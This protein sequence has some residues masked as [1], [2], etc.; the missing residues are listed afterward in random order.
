MKKLVFIVVVILSFSSCGSNISPNDYK[1]SE[2]GKTLVKW[3]NKESISIDM[4]GDKVLRNVDSIG[5][6]AFSFHKKLTSITL[7]KKLLRIGHSAFYGCDALKEIKI[8]NNVTYIGE[9]AFH[10]CSSLTN[11]NL[12]NNLEII[13]LALFDTCESLASIKIPN[14]VKSVRFN[15]FALCDK[16]TSITFPSSVESIESPFYRCPK[17][18]AVTVENPIPPYFSDRGNLGINIRYIYVPAKS[19]EAYKNAQGWRKYSDIIQAIP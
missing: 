2:D 17:L 3:L 4:Q 15:E 9:E 12:S 5:I 1:L 18:L 11:V 19:V 13:E 16:L 10:S 6:G 8:P 14:S 7:P